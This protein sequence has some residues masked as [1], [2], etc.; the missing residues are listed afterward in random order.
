MVTFKVVKIAE[1]IEDGKF[2]IWFVVEG[3]GTNHHGMLAH[4]K[5]HFPYHYYS[6]YRADLH[7][8]IHSIG[9]RP[10]G[11]ELDVFKQ[12]VEGCKI[13]GIDGVTL[14]GLYED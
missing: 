12:F 3:E 13:W 5:R 2:R 9:D 6:D 14:G 10:A 4:F 7:C 1:G 8:T 11:D